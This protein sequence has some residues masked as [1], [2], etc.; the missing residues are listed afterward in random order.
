MT[1]L[2]VP[3][4]V[5]AVGGRPGGCGG[6]RL[7]CRRTPPLSLSLSLPEVTE[8]GGCVALGVMY[9]IYTFIYTSIHYCPADNL[10]PLG[11]LLKDVRGRRT[12]RVRIMLPGVPQDSLSFSRNRCLSPSLSLFPPFSLSL[13]PFLSISLASLSPY[14]VTNEGLSL[15]AGWMLGGERER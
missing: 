12:G 5:G 1:V 4:S 3:S 7:A 2:C 14:Q 8:K 11:Q 10:L 13:S 6:R 15:S 9:F